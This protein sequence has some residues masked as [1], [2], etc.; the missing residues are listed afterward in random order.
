MNAPETN[1]NKTN[2]TLE[3]MED[4]KKQLLKLSGEVQEKIARLEHLQNMQQTSTET[5]IEN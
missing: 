4:K 3:L 5:E 1:I 2:P